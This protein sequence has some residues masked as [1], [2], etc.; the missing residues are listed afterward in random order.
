MRFTRTEHKGIAAIL[1]LLFVL[2][3]VRLSIQ[4]FVNSPEIDS[5]AVVLASQKVKEQQ[6]VTK[7]LPAVKLNLNSADSLQLVALPGIGKGLAHR[8]LQRRRELGKFNN[9]DEVLAVYKFRK[10]TKKMLI[11]HSFVE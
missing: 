1:L 10:D 11:E 5:K 3:I 7:Q 9:M 4:F 2:V 6:P 8:I